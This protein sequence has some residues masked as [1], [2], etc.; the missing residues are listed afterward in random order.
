MKLQTVYDPW[1][2]AAEIIS[3]RLCL[4]PEPTEKYLRKLAPTCGKAF[5]KAIG[6]IN[7]DTEQFISNILH[8]DEWREK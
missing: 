3:H 1:K 8:Q 4:S 6:E 7:K 2:T 5:K